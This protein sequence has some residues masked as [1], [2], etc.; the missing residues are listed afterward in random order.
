MIFT[1]EEKNFK[2]K[3]TEILKEKYPSVNFYYFQRKMYTEKRGWFL[4]TLFTGYLF[5]QIEELTADF[6]T[7][8]RAIKGFCRILRDNRKPT[9]ITGSALEELKFLI[10]NG[11]VLGVSKVQFLPNQKIKAIAGPFV[12]YEG[13]IVKVNQKQKRITVRSLLIDN[14]LTFDLKYE[15]VE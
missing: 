7:E 8:L 2:E 15:D 3:A 11:E 1:G 9:R 4:G 6:F 14:G 5:F 12:G 10:K 13:N